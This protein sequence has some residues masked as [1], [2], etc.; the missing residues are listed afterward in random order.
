MGVINDKWLN[1]YYRKTQGKH[2]GNNEDFGDHD[3]N[4]TNK[5]YQFEYPTATMVK[6]S[7]ED[8]TT[9]GGSLVQFFHDKTNNIS[10]RTVHCNNFKTNDLGDD[11]TGYHIH[12]TYFMGLQSANY[13]QDNRKN[14]SVTYT[15][16]E[17]DSKLSPVS[18]P[19]DQSSG[20]KTFKAVRSGKSTDN[21]TFYFD[22][23]YYNDFKDK[24]QSADAKDT[25]GDNWKA[26]TTW[27]SV[28]APAGGSSTS[29]SFKATYLGSS[30][31][32]DTGKQFTFANEYKSAFGSV[33]VKQ[34]T[35]KDAKDSTG[36][37]WKKGSTFKRDN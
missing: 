30:S 11:S 22:E 17:I 1:G 25:N 28:Y 2:D 6:L 4:G 24:K 34:A 36:S 10:C 29:T 33:G 35:S 9:S 5:G 13:M 26:G 3:N 37:T 23:K 21:G 12:I 19:P 8:F 20:K 16:K 18:P 32:A 7:G 14:T 15:A 27:T 31:P